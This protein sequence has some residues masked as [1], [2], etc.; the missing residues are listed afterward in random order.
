MVRNRHLSE[1]TRT[2]PWRRALHQPRAAA[3][4]MLGQD[5]AYD[6]CPISTSTT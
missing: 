4:A 1:E 6:E 3:Q 5:I 2:V